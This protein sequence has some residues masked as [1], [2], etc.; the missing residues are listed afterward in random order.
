MTPKIMD[1]KPAFLD[2]ENRSW[3][4]RRKTELEKFRERNIDECWHCAWLSRGNATKCEA[5]M[6][7]H[8]KDCGNESV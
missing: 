7:K 1:Y 5:C 8:Q 3:K 4:R 6:K 2:G